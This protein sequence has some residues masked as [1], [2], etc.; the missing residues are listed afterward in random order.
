M[1]KAMRINERDTVAILP[2]KTHVGDEVC[3]TGTSETYT[4]V[5]EIPAGHKI[6]LK[7]LKKGE[8]VIK[9]GI[10]IGVM[11]MD[12]PVGGWV[13]DHNLIDNTEEICTGYCKKYRENGPAG[14]NNKVEF[15]TDK[16]I[17]AYPRKNGAYGVRNYIMIFCTSLEANTMA[18]ELSN[19]TGVL[20]WVCD[21]RTIVDGH[22]SDTIQTELKQ[23]AINPNIYAALILGSD[24]DKEM[25]NS[26]CEA[27][28]TEGMKPIYYCAYSEDKHDACYRECYKMLEAW[29]QEALEMKR[30]EV[31]F[32][33][34][35]LSIHCGGSDWTTALYGNPTLGVASDLIVKNGGYVIMDEWAGLPGSEHLLASHAVD[36][37][38][39][40][41]IIDKVQGVRDKVFADTGKKVEE[42]NPFPS[43]KEGGI[44]TLVEK[45]TGNIKK[46]GSAPIQAILSVGDHPRIPG[47]YLQDQPSLTPYSTGMFAQLCGGHINVFVTGV[48]YVYYELTY[49][50]VIRTTGNPVSFN[51]KEYKLDFN[52]GAVMEGTPMSQVGQDLFD[53]IVAVAEGR[54]EPQS[55]IG[56]AKAFIMY[57]DEDEYYQNEYCRYKGYR[58]NVAA[59][60]SS[61]KG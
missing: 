55:E 20:W 5:D 3:I 21:K 33:G 2:V 51:T 25:N 17:L 44:T 46:A 34:F 19:N 30:Q 37:D 45:S 48:G 56:K 12:C 23:A 29:K 14:E 4:A 57:N 40:V 32:A 8:L 60:V 49:M 31:P 39:G 47:I 26:I 9:Y 18:E 52:S 43:N 58:N 11:G 59:K 16:K 35:T 1:I 28:K 7:D 36:H 6:A 61:I 10:P 53:Y 38:L 27:I 13:H 54:E 41:K 22:I 15:N 42:I 24:A 50:P